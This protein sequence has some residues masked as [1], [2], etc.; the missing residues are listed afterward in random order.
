MEN[1]LAVLVLVL[2]KSFYSDGIASEVGYINAGSAGLIRDITVQSGSMHV[3]CFKGVNFPVSV[4][5][6][7]QRK[8]ARL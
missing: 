1:H 3:L 5:T 4:Q 7:G 6:D 2:L 8:D